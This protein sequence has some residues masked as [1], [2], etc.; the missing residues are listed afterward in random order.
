MVAAAAPQKPALKVE[1]RK[2]VEKEG[3]PKQGLMLVELPKL[4]E[5]EGL[6]KQVGNMESPKPPAMVP[7]QKVVTLSHPGQQKEVATV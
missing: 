2:P 5:K 7:L 3:L 4:V 6:P 1:L